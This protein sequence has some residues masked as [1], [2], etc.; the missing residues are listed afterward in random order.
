MGIIALRYRAMGVWRFVP[1]LLAVAWLGFILSIIQGFTVD[2][3]VQL[4]FLFLT[5]VCWLL[6]GIGLWT[7]AKQEAGPALPA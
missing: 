4:A 6:L 3:P 5:G 7:S 1:L 2:S